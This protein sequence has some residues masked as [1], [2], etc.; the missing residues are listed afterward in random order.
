MLVGS[1]MEHHLGPIP[2]KDFLHALFISN[3][4]YHSPIELV[5]KLHLQLLINLIDAVFAP[6]KENNLFRS[7]TAYL[8]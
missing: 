7:Y 1:C 5:G 6:A 8:P 3:I 4:G 2:C